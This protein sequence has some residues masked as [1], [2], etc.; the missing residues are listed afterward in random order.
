MGRV[1]DPQAT[2]I[3]PDDQRSV[4]RRSL[5]K[6]LG[7][8]GLASGLA[9]CGE[10][11]NR[12]YE[13]ATLD[14]DRSRMQYLGY[15]PEPTR[16]SVTRR[17][18]RTI[19]GAG[20]VSIEATS[21]V[22][23][24]EFPTLLSE[25]RTSDGGPGIF[26]AESSDDDDSDDNYIPNCDYSSPNP[27]DVQGD[28]DSDSGTTTQGS[29]PIDNADSLVV[30]T[31]P[32]PS[33]AGVNLNPLA[34]SSIR[35]L[36]LERTAEFERVCDCDIGNPDQIEVRTAS[37]EDTLKADDLDTVIYAIDGMDDT[38]FPETVSVAGE[39]AAIRYFAFATTCAADDVQTFLV[40]A[41]KTGFETSAGQRNSV[42]A[43]YVARLQY[44]SESIPRTLIGEDGVFTQ[45]R[46]AAY[47]DRFA[48][49]CPC[50][51]QSSK[52]TPT[53]QVEVAD[54]TPQTPSPHQESELEVEMA[55][56]EE[57]PAEETRR[58]WGS[59]RET[60][61]TGAVIDR[62]KAE[63]DLALDP[64]TITG[65]RGLKEGPGAYLLYGELTNEDWEGPT[66]PT[67]MASFDERR[68]FQMAGIAVGRLVD[69]DIVLSLSFV[70]AG[71]GR[72]DFRVTIRKGRIIGFE[73]RTEAE[74]ANL[75]VGGLTDSTLL[76][77]AQ[78]G[79]ELLG[80]NAES[81]LA[82][83][84][85]KRSG[86]GSSS[87]HDRK[88]IGTGFVDV[89]EGIRCA[90]CFLG[91][92][93]V[94]N[95]VNE[96]GCGAAAK[97]T[98]SAWYGRASSNP[99]GSAIGAAITVAFCNGIAAKSLQ[100][101]IG[102]SDCCVCQEIGFCEVSDCETLLEEGII[103]SC[104][105]CSCDDGGGDNGGGGTGGSGG[106]GTG[107]GGTGGGGFGGG[108]TGNWCP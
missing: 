21:H 74:S 67:Y 45:D 33:F 103:N 108:G 77:D 40:V 105:C 9:G 2:N 99:L 69:G 85:P 64:D 31:F 25:R 10:V 1:P 79:P 95:V 35:E 27:L 78:S 66:T 52:D 34:R 38:G 12:R 89:L 24:W 44:D 16:R 71:D 43:A 88:E 100:W 47:L 65:M 42:L 50:L 7:T 17:E 5:L 59:A 8:A 13:A 53:E 14:V 37:P 36:I 23:E 57:V 72:T 48:L 104:G 54:P 51:S 106:G 56:P 18:E 55:G 87:Y 70:P 6:G 91:M 41:A 73:R 46:V 4:S 97:V 58:L 26:S 84:K 86:D 90:V 61:E 19:G 29:I 82:Y 49:A 15:D 22:S 30:R 94:K 98:I 96:L 107:G 28:L 92:W 81:G 101:A 60:V 102:T 80:T 32:D 39:E 68:R 83:R 3:P 11:V 20:S 75:T 76:G 63:F 62:A 93:K